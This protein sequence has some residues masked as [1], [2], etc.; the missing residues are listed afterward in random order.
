MFFWPRFPM[1]SNQTYKGNSQPLNSALTISLLAKSSSLLKLVLTNSTSRN[2]FSKNYWRIKNPSGVP[3]KSP[4]CISNATRKKDCDC[5]P[6]KKRHFQKFRTSG[7][8]SKHSR[9]RRPYRFFKKRSSSSVNSH[10]ENQADVS[11]V[12]KKAIMP[13][14]VPTKE[15]NSSD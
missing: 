15:K 1:S 7:F 9:S 5:S 10:G 12:R 6:K 11:Y 4:I 3:A 8:P 14:I 2:N 13:K